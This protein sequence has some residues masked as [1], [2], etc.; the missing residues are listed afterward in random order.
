MGEPSN[1][2]R[3]MASVYPRLLGEPTQVLHPVLDISDSIPGHHRYL[4]FWDL[5][6]SLMP[7]ARHMLAV[8]LLVD[9]NIISLLPHILREVMGRLI[10]ASS[11]CSQYLQPNPGSEAW[12]ATTELYPQLDLTFFFNPF[13]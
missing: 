3:Y 13:F 7:G 5:P 4:S 8:C 12:Q 11:F 2:C 1:P 10:Q 6:Q 9:P